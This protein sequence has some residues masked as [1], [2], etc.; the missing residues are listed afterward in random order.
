MLTCW[1]FPGHVFPQMSIAHALRERGCDVA[2]YTAEE[3]RNLVESEGFRF[4]PFRALKPESYERIH[5]MEQTVGGRRQSARV[6]HQAFRNWLVETIPEQVSDIQVILDE[7]Q[8]D[9]IVT[10]MNMWGPIL[11]LWEAVPIPVALLSS[12]GSMIPGP[13]APPWGFGM[14]PPRTTGAKILARMLNGT[15]DVA[16]TG[17]RRRV[18]FFRAQHGLEPMGC[19][20]NEFA[21]RL[22][23]Y[24]VGNVREFDYDRRDLPESVQYVGACMWHP[25]RLA[26]G[27]TWLDEIPS[28]MP[29]VHV[30]EGTSHFQD[31]FVLRSALEGLADRSMQVI[32]TAGR[33][34]DVPVEG[35]LAPNLH[36]VDWV[37]HDTLLPRCAAIVTTG[38]NGTVMSAMKAGVPLVIVPT[39]WDKPDNARRVV[40]AGAGVRLA[41]RKCTPEGL[42][43][44][45]ED[46]LSDERYRTNARRIAQHLANAPGPPRAAQLIERLAQPVA[47][48]M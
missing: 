9:V 10:D 7:W 30:T 17:L 44:A 40:E 14:A 35:D 24:I 6:G 47:V 32:V 25:P 27:A 4:F 34:R 5:Q 36:L 39:T 38:G 1:P 12:L 11:I 15:I 3:S 37:N 43:A 41:P 31:P 46:V 20:V 22:P 21:G 2:I 33:S 42:R 18:D 26:D 13:D 19:S 48:P 16:A 45:V 8:P 28:D 23:L 29:W